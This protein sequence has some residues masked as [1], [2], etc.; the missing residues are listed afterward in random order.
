MRLGRSSGFLHPLFELIPPSRSYNK[1]TTKISPLKYILPS[2]TCAFSSHSL[3]TVFVLS[4]EEE[5]LESSQQRAFLQ[6]CRGCHQVAVTPP[7]ISLHLQVQAFLSSVPS[8]TSKS[9]PLQKFLGRK[10]TYDSLCP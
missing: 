2:Y 7:L 10:P 6:G 8:R 5:R 9:T 3:W 4:V 1:A